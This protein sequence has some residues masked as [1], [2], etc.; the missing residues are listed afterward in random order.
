MAPSASLLPAQNTSSA[1]AKSVRSKCALNRPFPPTP[2]KSTSFALRRVVAVD[3]IL[4]V[5]RFELV[6]EIGLV[7]ELRNAVVAKDHV[8]R[9]AT[10]PDD[11]PAFV[12]RLQG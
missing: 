6:L 11:R 2:D 1:S 9:L 3:A 12:H 10:D 7:H 5:C 8:T 4:I